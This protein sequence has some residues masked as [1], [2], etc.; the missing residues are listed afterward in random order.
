L[1]FWRLRFSEK[2]DVKNVQIPEGSTIR[3]VYISRLRA[4]FP[5]SLKDGLTPNLHQ[6]GLRESRKAIK[7]LKNLIIGMYSC[8]N[9]LVFLTQF[10]EADPCLDEEG[11]PTSK[12]FEMLRFFIEESSILCDSWDEPEL[13]F[14]ESRSKKSYEPQPARGLRE[15]EIVRICLAAE[16]FNFQFPCKHKHDDHPKPKQFIRDQHAVYKSVAREPILR[17]LT[18]NVHWALHAI[19]FFSWHAS[20]ILNL[21]GPFSFHFSQLSF[22]ELPKLWREPLA[23]AN[24]KKLGRVWKGTYAFIERDEVNTLRTTCSRHGF[25]DQNISNGNPIQTMKMWVPGIQDNVPSNCTYT[26]KFEQYLHTFTKLR[27]PLYSGD[28][29]VQKA[30]AET[31]GYEALGFDEE[32]FYATGYITPLPPQRGIPG[33]QRIT[34]MKYF[35]D[36]RTDK[37]DMNALWAYEGVILPGGQMIVGRWWAPEAVPESQQYSGPFILWCVDDAYTEKERS[38]SSKRSCTILL[39]LELT[40][41]LAYCN[42]AS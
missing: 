39:S 20:A 14:T 10:T 6:L 11:S 24:P 9:R 18:V 32:D 38:V 30:L 22:E 31:Y 23:H 35:K 42:I 5:N 37:V 12:N 34:M 29:D 15:L 19:N 13:V 25:D 7:V 33:F 36:K 4:L 2:F 40:I 8:F 27:H 3:D 26:P 17:G 21:P 28:E 16:Q 1:S 41:S